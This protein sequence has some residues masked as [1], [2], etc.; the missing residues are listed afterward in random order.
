MNKISKLLT[1]NIDR[2]YFKK[3]LFHNCK[4][5]CMNVKLFNDQILFNEDRSYSFPDEGPWEIEAL[6]RMVVSLM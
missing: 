2:S 5:E 3:F 4:P 6:L 1:T